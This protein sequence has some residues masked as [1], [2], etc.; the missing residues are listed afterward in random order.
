MPKVL[1]PLRPWEPRGHVYRRLRVVEFGRL[2]R[3]PPLRFLNS[4][5][6]IDGRRSDA[7]QVRLYA[8]SAEAT[9]FWA[10]VLLL[11]YIGVAGLMGRGGGL[12]WFLLA[13]PL[14]DVYP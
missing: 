10:A 12:L 2:L 6:Y 9:H 7:L 5:V 4:A 3:Q 1:R 11:P 13:Q 14:G 8:E